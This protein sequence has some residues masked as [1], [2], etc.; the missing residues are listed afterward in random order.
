MLMV[1]TVLSLCV[2]LTGNIQEAAVLFWGQDQSRSIGI[3]LFALYFLPKEQ[4]KQHRENNQS[5]VSLFLY[6]SGIMSR[7]GLEWST[8]TEVGNNVIYII[9]SKL[10][11]SVGCCRN[12][13]LS[14]SILRAVI[15]TTGFIVYSRNLECQHLM[16]MITLERLVLRRSL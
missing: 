11:L 13:N 4:C 3:W 14:V 10:C 12:T 1:R 6:L 7:S 15:K 5:Q 16:Q 9:L 2:K 8:H